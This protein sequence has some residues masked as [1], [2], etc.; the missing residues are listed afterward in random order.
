MPFKKSREDEDSKT[1]SSLATLNELSCDDNIIHR[2]HCKK[3]C[4]LKNCCVDSKAPFIVVPT[5]IGKPLKWKSCR[6]AKKYC[7][8]SP[9]VALTCP[10]TCGKCAPLS[11]EDVLEMIDANAA[12]LEK[13]VE[14]N[15][16]LLL[17]IDANAADLEKQVET[18]HEQA[19]TNIG[20]KAKVNN[21]AKG[22]RFGI[23]EYVVVPEFKLWDD[24]V[25]A[26][27]EWGGHLASVHSADEA[28]FI[29]GL[30][31]RDFWV[32]ID[33]E[34]SGDAFINTDGT[35]FDYGNWV[36]GHPIGEGRSNNVMLKVNERELISYPKDNLD[37]AQMAVYK[38]EFINS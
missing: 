32:W 16:D 23:Y 33:G 21:Q 22:Y 19:L 10:V 18:N 17:K 34:L 2:T 12:K 3:S 9:D 15:N 1:C 27:K 30:I 35:A 37:G 36:N 14:T 5:N 29:K 20:L 25:T 7:E 6:V 13:Q 8:R 26:A 4:S 11:I 28:Q 38:K 24:H 31:G